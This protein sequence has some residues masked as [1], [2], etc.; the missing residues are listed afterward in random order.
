MAS[1]TLQLTVTVQLQFLGQSNGPEVQQGL[2]AL[3]DL[4]CNW[5]QTHLKAP[6]Y[7]WYY[8]TQAKF[9]KGG[10]TWFKW[11]NSFAK[12]LVKAQAKD[13]HYEN[14]TRATAVS[15]R[16][17]EASQVLGPAVYS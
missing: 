6:M 3:E 5:N 1:S 7:G 8:I 12:A 11:N 14:R 13:G 15:W 17:P 16:C 10:N 4:T 2:R 9:H